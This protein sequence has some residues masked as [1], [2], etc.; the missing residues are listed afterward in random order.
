MVIM[1]LEFS[2]E[3]EEL[4][5]EISPYIVGYGKLADEALDDIKEKLK[6]YKE[7]LAEY[8]CYWL[9]YLYRSLGS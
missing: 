6:R 4:F 5:E 8:A 7:L 1:K 9:K 2:D 3:V